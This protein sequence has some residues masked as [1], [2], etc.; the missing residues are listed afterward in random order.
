[1]KITTID[2]N[3]D[4]DK[5][6]IGLNNTHPLLNEALKEFLGKENDKPFLIFGN[7]DIELVV[8]KNQK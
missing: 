5:L 3:R 8:I 6:L 4:T 1:M 7:E 2:F